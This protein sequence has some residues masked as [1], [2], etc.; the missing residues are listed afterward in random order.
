M[1][2]TD[3]IEFKGITWDHSRALPPL[4][5]V[6]QRFEELHPGIR[7]RWEK[8]TLHE[9]GHM[10]IDLLA[11]RYDFIVMDHP[12]AGYCLARELVHDLR[13][14]LGE[15]SFGDLSSRFIGKSFESYLYQGKLLALPIDAATPAPS[16]R[17][18]LLEQVGVA[19]PRSW[20]DLLALADKKLAAMPGFP[21]DLFLNW[22]MLLEAL[23]AR[24]FQDNEQIADKKPALEAMEM[25]KRLAEGMTHAI[26]DWNPIR[27]AESMT[28]TDAIAYCPFAYSYGNYSRPSF[29]ERPLRY[30]SLVRMENARP[31]RSIIGGTGL[32][33]TRRC[34]NLEMALDFARFCASGPIQKGI[35]TYSGGQ[36]AHRDAWD[37][38]TEDTSFTGGFFSHTRQPHEEAIVRPRYDGYV[39]LQERTGIPLQQFLKGEWGRDK[40]WDSI[41]AGYR[42]SRETT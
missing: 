12:W 5:A 42:D 26:Y 3:P 22:C 15:K 37:P 30:G 1:S 19:P 10:P 38:E 29:V 27:L 13:P 6:A 25:L 7:F 35:Y 33:V 39:P 31:L 32:A 23:E 16:W 24:P 17:P 8:R 11:D 40:T 41:N 4:V 9:F 36:P 34:A 14:L 28:Q 2:M 21:A 18:D 20:R